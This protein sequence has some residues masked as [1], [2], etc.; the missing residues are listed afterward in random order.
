MEIELLHFLSFYAVTQRGGA[1]PQTQL[2]NNARSL[3]ANETERGPRNG[4]S[5]STLDDPE[6]QMITERWA[7]FE[8]RMQK[9][10]EHI[11]YQELEAWYQL[12]FGTWLVASLMMNK[13]LDAKRIFESWLD[14]CQIMGMKR[15]HKNQEDS[16]ILDGVIKK[17]KYK[18]FNKLIK[19]WDTEVEGYWQEVVRMKMEKNMEWCNFLRE[20]CNTWVNYHFS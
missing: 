15:Y 14:M 9:K 18:T 2:S 17:L 7:D 12:L 16:E 11:E 6:F 1:T 20:N 13:S 3:A 19:D 8:E 10:W 5:T 4:P